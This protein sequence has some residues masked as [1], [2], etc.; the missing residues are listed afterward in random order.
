MGLKRTRTPVEPI[1]LSRAVIP[2]TNL[3]HANLSNANLV[4]ANLSGANLSMATLVKANLADATLNN[5]SLFYANLSDANLAGA[6]LS[7]ANVKGAHFENA[8]LHMTK[9]YKVDWRGVDLSSVQGLSWFQVLNGRL[10]SST[11][12]P[13]YLSLETLLSWLEH[14]LP[15]VPWRGDFEGRLSEVL[16]FLDNFV[17]RA[18]SSSVDEAISNVRLADAMDQS[19]DQVVKLKE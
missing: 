11:K 13:A 5:A 15:A 9:M 4:G 1:D 14:N 12:L 6:D 10:D 8:I 3:S 16:K 17:E 19:P 7:G 2:R 18:R